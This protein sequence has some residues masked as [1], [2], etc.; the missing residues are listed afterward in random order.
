MERSPFLI[1]II[2]ALT[3][4]SCSDNKVQEMLQ[5]PE[6]DSSKERYAMSALQF[7]TT[8]DS[9]FEKMREPQPGEWLHRFY[10][11]G[12]TFE[13]YVNCDPT[14]RTKEQSRI[15]LLP[16]GHFTEK[17]REL[18]LALR[19]FTQIFFDCPTDIADGIDLPASHFRV[20]NWAGRTWSQYLTTYFLEE[21]LPKKLPGD[22][23]CCLGITIADLYPDESW[24]Y[25]FGEATVRE[26][27]GIYSLVRYF[28]AFWGEKETP[29]SQIQA[30]RRSCKTLCHEI[31]HMFTI[32]HCIF[33]NCG[34]SGSNSL[35]ES[36]RR[37]LFFCPICLKKLQWNLKFDVLSRYEKL[38]KF[39]ATNGLAEEVRW[40]Q[41]RVKKIRQ[42]AQSGGK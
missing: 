40:L 3:G 39:F 8:D 1:L 12:Q 36:D 18:L 7:A 31:G 20:R 2:F 16:I 34:M 14:T 13:E 38:E 32:A 23:I 15:V 37:L 30:L 4:I 19:E 6:S 24:N 22:A 9:D 28:P 25:V 41:K 27:V 26:R 21:V 42:F 17:E 11:R 29:E 35:A 33:Y 10:E 5:S